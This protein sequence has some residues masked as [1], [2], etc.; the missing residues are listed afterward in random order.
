VNPANTLLL[1]EALKAK[2]SAWKRISSKSAAMVL[3]CAARL[4]SLWPSGP[5]YG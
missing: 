4:A 3:A 1:R 2:G 5:S